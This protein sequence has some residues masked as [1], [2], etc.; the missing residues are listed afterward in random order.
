MNKKIEFLNAL[1]ILVNLVIL[2]SNI[3]KLIN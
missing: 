3:S 2:I 1:L